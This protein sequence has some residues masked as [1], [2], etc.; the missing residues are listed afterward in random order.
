M[1]ALSVISRLP[2]LGPTAPPVK[3]TLIVQDLVAARVGPHVV[4][5]FAKSLAL[6]PPNVMEAILTVPPA[7]FVRVTFLG[8]EVIP[9][10]WDPKE[11][12]LGVKV[13]L[14]SE[15]TE[16]G[17]EPVIATFTVSVAVMVWGPPVFRV[18]PKL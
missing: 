17:A 6:A 7:L 5:D 9:A 8:I 3:V 14:P 4:A 15:E 2:D 13:K 16:T 11:I 18:A 10:T 1:L 12:E